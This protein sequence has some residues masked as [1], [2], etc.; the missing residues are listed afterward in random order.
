MEQSKQLN[1]IIPVNRACEL[2][3]VSRATICRIEKRGYLTGIPKRS[4]YLS[5][6]QFFH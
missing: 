1:D 3:N 6:V 2:L 4:Y 5:Q